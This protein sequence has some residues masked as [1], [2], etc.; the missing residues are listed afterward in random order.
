MIV[1]KD[2]STFVYK[3]IGFLF[4]LTL[5]EKPAF[6]AVYAITGQSYAGSE[7][8]PIYMIYLVLLLV[9]QFCLFIY[10]RRIKTKEFI[11]LFFPL[12]FIFAALFFSFIWQQPLNTNIIRNVI[13]WQYTGIFLA[14]NIN[15]YDIDTEII[16]S[17]VIL[18]LLITVGSVFSVLIPFFRGRT[19]SLLEGYSL[20]GNTFQTQSYFIALATGINLFFFLPSAKSTITKIL[21]YILLGVQIVSAILYAGRGAILLIIAYIIAFYII[22]T[23]NSDNFKKRLLKR[24]FYLLICTIIVFVLWKIIQSSSFIQAR[25]GRVFS[26]LGRKGID[27][28]QTSNRD[29]LYSSALYHVGRSPVWGYGILGYMYLDGLNRYPHNIALE[30]LLEGGIIYFSVWMV[31]I[32]SGFRK[33]RRTMNINSYLIFLI[34]FMFSIIQLLFSGSYSYDM[35]FWFSIVFSHIYV[36][37]KTQVYDYAE[38]Q[39]EDGK[40]KQVDDRFNE[41]S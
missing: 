9:I 22:D 24:I 41:F 25:F 26:Y 28:S 18:M 40:E 33:I 11:I 2:D 31:V 38:N 7:S 16:K 23:R 13:L 17:L 32:I 27:L 21:S 12:L 8:S 34:P 5:L 3:I 15:S 6:F 19:I 4:A 36:D 39:L 10:K 20:T 1:S 37:K 29:V 35:L 30:M 14:I